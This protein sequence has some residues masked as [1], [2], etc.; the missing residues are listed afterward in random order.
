MEHVKVGNINIVSKIS[1]INFLP[2]NYIYIQI[3][4][5]KQLKTVTTFLTQA[6][7]YALSSPLEDATDTLLELKERELK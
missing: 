2:S 1:T 7:K 5:I 3:Y 4:T 6:E